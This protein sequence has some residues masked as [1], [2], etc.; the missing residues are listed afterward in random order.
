MQADN[1]RSWLMININPNFYLY[2]GDK[3]AF[4][5]INRKANQTELEG[6]VGTEMP[7]FNQALESVSHKVYRG[8]TCHPYIGPRLNSIS[9]AIATSEVKVMQMNELLSEPIA[10]DVIAQ[11]MGR[12]MEQ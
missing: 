11:S 8:L 12:S 9:N 7:Q 1:I 5:L 2:N 4:G 10:K 3:I 6:L